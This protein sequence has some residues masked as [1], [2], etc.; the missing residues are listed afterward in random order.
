MVTATYI[1]TYIQTALYDKESVY[2]EVLDNSAVSTDTDTS[3]ETVRAACEGGLPWK[4]ENTKK[5]II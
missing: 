2:T 3:A 4:N 1:H 5:E